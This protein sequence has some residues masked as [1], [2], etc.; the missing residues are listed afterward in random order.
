MLE[1][2][3]Y[4]KD[5]IIFIKVIVDISDLFDFWRVIGEVDW[6]EGNF[7]GGF[8][9]VVFIEVFAFRKGFCG[10]EEAVEGGRGSA[11]GVTREDRFD[12]FFID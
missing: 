4:I 9:S 10:T 1:N 5:D 7:F 8:E 6:V 2:G 12:M 11:G 3:I